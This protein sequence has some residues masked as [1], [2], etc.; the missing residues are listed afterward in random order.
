[1]YDEKGYGPSL[2]YLCAFEYLELNGNNLCT[3]NKYKP[4]VFRPLLIR[5]TLRTNRH[6]L[7][8]LKIVV[9]CNV[10]NFFKVSLFQNYYHT[11][12]LFVLRQI[13]FSLP[14]PHFGPIKW[15]PSRYW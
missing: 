2:Q 14:Y 9:Y 11:V 3:Q 6:M 8:K 7:S 1:M 5:V 10:C 15:N 4:R 13:A 12:I